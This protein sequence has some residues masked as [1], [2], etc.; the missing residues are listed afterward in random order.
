MVG[1]ED[2]VTEGREEEST[3]VLM[4]TSARLHADSGHGKGG[5]KKA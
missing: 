1:V 4:N 3:D 5:G 2:T